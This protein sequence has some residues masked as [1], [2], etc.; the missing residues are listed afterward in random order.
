MRRSRARG[1][2][3]AFSTRTG[4]SLFLCSGAGKLFAGLLLV[5]VVGTA[6]GLA[7]L[8]PG[9]DAGASLG[10]LVADSELGE[11]RRIE[12]FP[13][14]GFQTDTCRR[15]DVALLSGPDEDGTATLE[16]GT[17]A[18][19]PDLSVGDRLRVA[20]QVA[21][22]GGTTS[23]YT[24][25]D[26]E[27]RAP[28]LWLALAFVALVVVFGR[29]R[30]A[31]SLLG[32]ALSLAVVVVF[33]VPAIL[34]GAAPLAVAIV[35]SFAIMLATIPLAHGLGPKSVAAMLGSG[36]SL[37]LTVGLAVLFTSLTNLTGL[38]SEEA[39]T[40]QVNDAGVSFQGL[41]LAGIVIG[42]LGV[43]DDMTVSQAS[44]V[45]SLRAA[46]PAQRFGDLYRGGLRVGRDHVSATVNT[47]V[48]AYV[49]AALP[50]LLI[51]SSGTVGFLE[52]LNFEIV[53]KEI[54]ATLV[55][56]IGLI[57]AAPITTA[58]AA[59]LVERLPVGGAGGDAPPHVH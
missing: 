34:E 36:A 27:R 6:V 52:V 49:G 3:G 15:V 31:L 51:F 45:M 14:S 58:L 55:G 43:L 20:A 18:I 38:S 39:T 10:S 32:L 25:V 29:L 56:S 8:W 33:V 7:V 22:G 53:A 48:L 2:V 40:L 28:M 37:L 13:C 57:A 54:V 59:L 35:G 9:K 26:F 42:A 50:V 4:A 44:T 23:T 12:S 16:L 30:G 19:D 11:V 1:G 17:S 46:N 41:L 5:L 21:P 24:L 47:L